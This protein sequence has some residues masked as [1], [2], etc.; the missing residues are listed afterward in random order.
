M[1]F[2]KI[3]GPEGMQKLRQTIDEATLARIPSP[4]P[5]HVNLFGHP[6]SPNKSHK[7]ASKRPGIRIN[8]ASQ[9]SAQEWESKI[10]AV[11]A[12]GYF[13]EQI[14]TEGNMIVLKD[15]NKVYESGYKPSTKDPFHWAGDWL[16]AF[17]DDRWEITT[18]SLNLIA[19]T[20]PQGRFIASE[21]R[22]DLSSGESI[23][24]YARIVLKG[25]IRSSDDLSIKMGYTLTDG[26]HLKSGRNLIV[27]ADR[28]VVNLRKNN[29]AFNRGDYELCDNWFHEIACHAGRLP[30]EKGGDT[31][32]ADHGNSD[33][34]RCAADIHTMTWKDKSGMDS[35]ENITPD[36]KDFFS[37]QGGGK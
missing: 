37:R 36:V 21:L 4:S 35:L 10:K 8:E 5:G 25:T 26:L 9:I 31:T 28:I 13:S 32:V 2:G 27:I 23:D 7:V 29:R 18:A 3:P 16:Q 6:Q 20:D 17:T 1:A 22:P 12:P 24:K 30:V 19:A 34:D 14:E 33:V 11:K 15:P